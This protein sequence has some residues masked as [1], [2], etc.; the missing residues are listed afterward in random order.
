MRRPLGWVLLSRRQA[1]KTASPALLGRSGPRELQ[2]NET[3][4]NSAGGTATTDS[5]PHARSGRRRGPRRKGRGLRLRLQEAEA[6]RGVGAARSAAMSSALDLR[7]AGRC[8]AGA[9][10]GS[11]ARAPSGFAGWREELEGLRGKLSG[12]LGEAQL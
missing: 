1:K 3:D 4:L 7:G 8:Q 10:V 2:V 5:H 9:R 11:G 12:P 6:G